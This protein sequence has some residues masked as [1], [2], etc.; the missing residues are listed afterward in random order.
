MS[1]SETDNTEIESIV[2][3]DVDDVFKPAV[4]PLERF[5]EGVVLD[6]PLVPPPAPL[7]FVQ[8]EV[9]SQLR[10]D[11]RRDVAREH[12]G[13]LLGQVHEDVGGRHFIV[14]TASLLAAETIGS[15]VHLQFSEASWPALW[16]RM[17]E[18]DGSLMVGWYHTHPGL[19][20]FL[21][22]TDRRTQALYFSQPWQIAIVIDPVRDEI[23]FFCGPAG[24]KVG[25]VRAFRER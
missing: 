11:A 21:S 17:K 7:I 4:R 18:C 6:P 23:G 15:A 8:H 2:W 16:D 1:Q 19:G 10:D 20:V 12:G 25:T 5:L 22:G 24:R 13:I 3:R 9:L 14:V